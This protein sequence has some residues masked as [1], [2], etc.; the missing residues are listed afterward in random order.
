MKVKFLQFKQFKYG[1][2]KY[3]LILLIK[4]F[5]NRNKSKNEIFVN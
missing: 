2:I 4:I 1:K 5:K 3:F